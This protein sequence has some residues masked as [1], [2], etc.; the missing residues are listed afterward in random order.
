MASKQRSVEEII[1]KLREGE[2]AL[3][4]RGDGGPGMQG[5]RGIGPYVLPMAPA[6]WGAEDRPGEAVA[7]DGSGERTTQ[8]CG[9]G[10]DVGQPDSKGGS[11]GKLLSPA[12]RRR[13]VELARERYGI[14]ERRACRAL[15]QPRS[16]QRYTATMAD[17]E[18]A[19]TMAVVRLASRYGR[20]GYRRVTAMLQWEGWRVNHKRVERIWR[21]GGLKVPAKQ[22]KRGRPWLT[23]GSCVRLRPQRRNHVW[24]YAFV[25]LR[26]SDGKPV[27]LLTVVDEYTR[28]CLAIHVGRSLRSPHVIECLGDLIV[29]RGVPEHLRSD[30]GPEFT[31]RAV[32]LWL[33]PLGATTLFITP[34]SP[35]ENGYVESF[36]GKL[37]DELLD[38]ELF[39]TLWEVQVLTEQWRHEYNHQRPHSALGYRPP[40]PEAILTSSAP[41]AISVS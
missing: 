21:R 18:E 26:T 37:R 17:D 19:L 22:P 5:Y 34:G 28:E 16:T 35:W 13:C 40:A 1:G 31:A 20:Y 6:V 32:R 29:Q 8:A 33:P 2:V 25:A 24:A 7:G 11:T 10:P 15:E 23:D 4:A 3:G 9:S 27:R 14:S 36:N 38:R 12:R 39:D 41:S 30:N